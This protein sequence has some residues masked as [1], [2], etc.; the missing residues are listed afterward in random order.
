MALYGL[1]AQI[2]LLCDVTIAAALDDATNHVKLSRREPVSLAL[3]C[4]CLAHQLVKCGD[5]VDDPFSTYPVVTGEDRT[6]GGMQCT[7]QRILQDD[8]ACSYVKSLDDLLR[9][10]GGSEQEDLHRR[11]SAHDG[12]HGFEAGQA[13]HLNVEKQDV[14][15]QLKGLSNG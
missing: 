12:T 2:E 5:Q 6:N 1:L 7:S 11:R 14:G 4:G 3:G 15:R 9:R 8:S 13:R 10:K